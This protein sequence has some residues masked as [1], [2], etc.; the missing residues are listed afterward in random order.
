VSD[1]IMVPNSVPDR[2]AAVNYNEQS[3][4]GGAMSSPISATGFSPRLPFAAAE[5]APGQATGRIGHL[6]A[7]QAGSEPFV[8]RGPL[9]S[10]ARAAPK[11]RSRT[12]ATIPSNRSDPGLT[13]ALTNMRSYGIMNRHSNLY[14]WGRTDGRS[15]QPGANGGGG[16]ARRGAG[17]A[18]PAQA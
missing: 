6:P 11:N 3:G 17:V 12:P 15:D 18:R 13:T 9:S 8:G 4:F 10:Q 7:C 5:A 16:P 2:P 14:E 1:S